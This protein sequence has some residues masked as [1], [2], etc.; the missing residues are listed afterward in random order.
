[1]MK[2]LH[3]NLK[4]PG[5]SGM[6]VFSNIHRRFS[7]LTPKITVYGQNGDRVVTMDTARNFRLTAGT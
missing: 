7:E 4:N 2:G 5:T 6:A 3:A 1:M